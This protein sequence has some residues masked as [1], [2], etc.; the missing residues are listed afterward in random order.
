MRRT[1]AVTTPPDMRTPPTLPRHQHGALLI[2]LVIALGVLAAAVFVGMLSS[3]DIQNQRDKTTAAALAEAKAA[4][5]GWSVS[6]YND[7]ATYSPGQLP[8]PEDVSKIGTSTEGTAATSCN[9]LATSPAIGRLPWRTLGVGDLRDGYGE[10]L[11]YV[12]S[13]GFRSAPI[14]SSDSVAQLT[15]DGANSAVAIIFSPGSLL[16]GQTRTPPTAASPPNRANYLDGTNVDGDNQFTTQGTP[17]N[18][19][20]RLI[21]V[22]HRDLFVAV[23]KSIAN[24]LLGTGATATSGLRYVYANSS[25]VGYPAS[26]LDYGGMHFTTGTKN[27]FTQNKWDTLIVYPP[28]S[29]TAQF[30]MPTYCSASTTNGQEGTVTCP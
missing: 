30:S 5:I 3:S 22:S 2:L 15:V 4:L 19:N 1:I 13:S 18:F 26:P 12:I 27:M 23:E 17:A 9:T 20:D 6:R 21:L 28:P 11:W 8:C 25:P 10:R 14:N 16:T 24:T 7:T 29:N